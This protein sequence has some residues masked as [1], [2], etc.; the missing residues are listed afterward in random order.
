MASRVLRRALPGRRALHTSGVRAGLFRRGPEP[1]DK[2]PDTVGLGAS[3]SLAERLGASR[4]RG[5]YD[6][7][8][9][10]PLYVPVKARNVE[11]AWEIWSVNLRDAR[12]EGPAA[13]AAAASRDSLAGLLMLLVRAAEPHAAEDAAEPPVAEDAVR[14]RRV[15][16]HRVA[17]LLR[18]MFALAVRARADGAAAAEGPVGIGAFGL[19]LGLGSADDYAGVAALLLAA[20]ADGAVPCGNTLPLQAPTAEELAVDL[21]GAPHS[22]LAQ[23][24]VRAAIDDGIQPTVAILRPA[25]E[26]AA[27]M[28]DTAAARDILAPC[29][30]DLAAL[31]DP[32]L[33]ASAPGAGARALD[34]PLGSVCGPLVEAALRVVEAGSDPRALD[35]AAAASAPQPVMGYAQLEGVV[36][37]CAGAEPA[38]ER[39]ATRA[40]RAAA[41]ERIYRAYVAAGIAEVPAP[42]AGPRPALRGSVVPTPQILASLLRVHLGAG[43]AEQAVVVYEALQAAVSRLPKQRHESAIPADGPAELGPEH[44]LHWRLWASLLRAASDAGHLWLAARVLGA[45]AGDGWAPT[46]AM[47]AQFLAALRDPTEAAL[48]EAV[49]SVREATA[50]AGV[51]ASE[52]AICDPLV[53]ALASAHAAFPAA[54]S[55]EQALL[56]SGLGTS[57]AGAVSDAA[58][59]AIIG[60]LIAAGQIARAQEL[61]RSW[62]AS[63][64]G[65][66][67]TQCLAGLVQGLGAAGQHGQALDLFAR[68]QQ[69]GEGEVTVGLLSAV[70]DVYVGAGEYSEAISVAKRIR[71]LVSEAQEAA[72][73]TDASDAAATAAEAALPSHATYNNMIH[74]YCEELQPE[75]A[76]FVLEEMRR[77][78]RH[79]TSETYTILALAM[80]HLR[81]YEG[82]KLVNGLVNVDYNMAAGEPRALPLETDY[83][84]GL[85]EAYGRIGKPAMALQVWEV[86]RFRGVR[87]NAQTATLLIDT[88]AWNERIHWADDVAPQTTYTPARVPDDS[89][90]SGVPLL[91]IH[92]LAATVEQLRQA[93][94]ELTLAHHQHL[95][96]ALVRGVFVPDM[97]DMLIGRFEGA[98]AVVSWKKKTHKLV[99]S[100][101]HPVAAKLMAVFGQSPGAEPEPEPEPGAEPETEAEAREREQER[102]R[103]RD[104]SSDVAR[105]LDDFVLEIPLCKE[106]VG[107]A[108]GALEHLR[109]SCSPENY[110]REESVVSEQGA[111]MVAELVAMH[112]AR[113]DRFLEQHRPELLPESRRRHKIEAAQ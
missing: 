6:R 26:T 62:S 10:M 57:G 60:A 64:P 20:A 95:I 37:Y 90:Y 99:F 105:M 13:A 35:A 53:C 52:P 11:K 36:D 3:P 4:R 59:R 15:A 41:A 72:A 84:N 38:G 83:F 102:K 66:V 77:Y 48:A 31:L 46:Q 68:F 75:E 55:V 71:A 81:S 76:M 51:P 65:L 5:G 111:A 50:A 18:Y 74:A 24:L 97:V 21:G 34:D 1:R 14:R 2:M 25:L 98:E 108:Y 100:K 94:L 28:R 22:R 67:T 101:L 104:S 88:C 92:Y 27:A 78:G 29:Y 23:A 82:L 91:H 45:M 32:D 12:S 93:G 63:R 70:L 56:L 39:D 47:H 73:A 89:V 85:I 87:P 19:G 109:T 69:S 33:P 112:E 9:G 42:D 113:L 43:N 86:M 8:A 58:A 107:T 44:R 61:A 49:E 79:A 30:A 80:S 7:G 16:A 103:A 96:E 17:A 54:A 106:T 40:W 110:D